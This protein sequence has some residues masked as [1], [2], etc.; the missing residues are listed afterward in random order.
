MTH[1]LNFSRSLSPS[2]TLRIT[3]VEGLSRLDS[4]N[5]FPLTAV[6]SSRAMTRGELGITGTVGN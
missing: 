2:A 1:D 3:K 4:I 5:Y 6:L